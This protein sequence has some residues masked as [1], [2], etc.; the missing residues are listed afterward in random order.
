MISGASRPPAAT[1]S[2][3]IASKPANM[4]ARTVSSVE[5]SQQREATDVDQSVADADQAEQ[6]D[7]RRLLG[8]DADHGQR[9]A[10]QRYADAEPGGEPATAN[11][12]ERDDRPEHATG[13]DGRVQD[14]DAR[15]SRVEQ[16]DRDHHREDGQAAARERL[17]HAESR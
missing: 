6:D 4:R 9:R 3:R 5:P 10:E 14:A 15:I 12:P 2:V 13:S 8:N 16:V 17:H 7:R 11:Q 1:P